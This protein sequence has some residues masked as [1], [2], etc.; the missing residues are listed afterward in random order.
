MNKIHF[1]ALCTRA[2]WKVRGL[3]MRRCYAEGGITAAHC[4][5]ST[6]F[7]NVRRVLGLS[8]YLKL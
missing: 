4:R 8:S 6:N 2:V 3:A 7:S 5:Q 1:I